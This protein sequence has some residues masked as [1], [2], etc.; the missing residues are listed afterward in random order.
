MVPDSSVSTAPSGKVA[1]TRK[2]LAPAERDWLSVGEIG[3]ST[4]ERAASSV[5]PPS[6][7]VCFTSSAYPGQLTVQVMRAPA[8]GR[9]ESCP[10]NSARRFAI[11][12]R[13]VLSPRTKA[14]KW[15]L[16][17]AMAVRSCGRSD[18]R[19]GCHPSA[20][21]RRR[22]SAR[23]RLNPHRSGNRAVRHVQRRLGPGRQRGERGD[24]REVE[25]G[26]TRI[27][28]VWSRSAR[29]PRSLAA[30]LLRTAS[31]DWPTARSP[32]V[33][34]LAQAA[35]APSTSRAMADGSAR[36]M[37]SMPPSPKWCPM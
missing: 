4:R 34:G 13:C 8:S 32:I 1:R 27:C 23:G 16:G 3:Q 36:S 7:S 21:C 20:R 37:L 35:P 22:R 17:T 15:Q 31:I 18:Q 29:A 10:E 14:G 26:H 6:A 19:I 11:K 28:S 33:R 30:R 9:S 5:R 12:A 25:A 2:G 24:G